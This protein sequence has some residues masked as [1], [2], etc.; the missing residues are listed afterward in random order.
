M[1]L[2]RV[3]LRTS[4]FCFC[5]TA[6]YAV[7]CTILV[8]VLGFSEA[9]TGGPNGTYRFFLELTPTLAMVTGLGFG[10]ATLALSMRRDQ[11]KLWSRVLG[12]ALGGVLLG[13]CF[14]LLYYPWALLFWPAQQGMAVAAAVL[15]VA[16]ELICR[17][18]DPGRANTSADAPGSV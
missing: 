2:A 14:C 10:L 6:T 8:Y 4:V 1:I 7:S 11:A 9:K 15:G 16:V 18:L 13:T 12:S 5:V 17:A 3:I